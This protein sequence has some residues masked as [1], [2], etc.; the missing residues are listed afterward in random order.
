[1]NRIA[2]GLGPP[3]NSSQAETRQLIEGKLGEEHEPKNVQVDVIELQPGVT[4][5]KLR[6]EG[7]VII[8]IPA[9]ERSGE[10][11]PPGRGSRSR[12]TGGSEEDVGGARGEP[13]AREAELMRTISPGS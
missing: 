1:V 12:S 13:T 11:Q 2:K 4:A 5:I 7:G 10:G 3:T 6:D 9:E 8:E